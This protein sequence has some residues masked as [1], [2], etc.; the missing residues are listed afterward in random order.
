MSG[1][2]AFL[3]RYTSS[4][5]MQKPKVRKMIESRVRKRQVKTRARLIESAYKLMSAKGVDDTTIQQITE[6]ADVGFGTFYSYF[7]SKDEIAASVLDCVIYNLGQRNRMANDAA[8]V[9][10]ALAII[11]N[12]VRLTALEMLNNPMWRWWLRRT[13]LMVRRMH[14]GFR[15]FGIRDLSE[16]QTAGQVTFSDGQIQTAWGYLI[17]LLAGTITDIV[18]GVRPPTAESDMAEAI[19]RVV[20]ASAADAKRVSSVA[21][22]KL[23]TMKIDFTFRPDEPEYMDF[24]LPK[25]A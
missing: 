21:L 25:S 16:A 1:G 3:S 23:P 9:T 17:W 13:D 7:A 14:V 2:L 12:S 8:G 5:E 11:S 22:P 24:A 19:M 20:G 10:D 15:P 4:E 18:E 6:R